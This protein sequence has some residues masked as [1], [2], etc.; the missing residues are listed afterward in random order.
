MHKRRAVIVP[1]MA[2]SAM[3]ALAGPASAGGQPD[4]A[5][6]GLGIAIVVAL[7]VAGAFFVSVVASG[8]VQRRRRR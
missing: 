4:P 5:P 7:L 2:L 8:F 1:M 3:L 6:G